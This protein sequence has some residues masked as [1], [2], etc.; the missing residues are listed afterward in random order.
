[1]GAVGLMHRIDTVAAVLVFAERPDLLSIWRCVV[2]PGVGRVAHVHAIAQLAHAS[3]DR[4]ADRGGSHGSTARAK[5]VSNGA[6]ISTTMHHPRSVSVT[7]SAG[8][9]RHVWRPA[10]SDVGRRLDA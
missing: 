8:A 9:V 7:L 1:S 5:C 6:H 10:S 2:E 4:G 3:D